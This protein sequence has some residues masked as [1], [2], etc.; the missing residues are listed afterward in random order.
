VNASC[1]IFPLAS[2]EISANSATFWYIGTDLTN[3]VRIYKLRG[4]IS[5]VGA[6][7]PNNIPLIQLCNMNASCWI[8]PAA[9]IVL[10]STSSIFRYS[11][12]YVT[13]AARLSKLGWRTFHDGAIQMHVA[14]FYEQH[15]LKYLWSQ[16]F[17]SIPVHISLLLPEFLGWGEKL[18]HLMG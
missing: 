1:S 17:F 9:L 11:C 14:P 4:Q 7:T 12:T 2:I 3:A 15:W 5:M 6:C 13:N 8:S 18:V 10:C 16:L